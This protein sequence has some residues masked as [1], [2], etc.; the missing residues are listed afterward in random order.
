[1][2]S[3]VILHFF[4]SLSRFVSWGAAFSNFQVNIFFVLVEICR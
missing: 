2:G 4:G 1:M 3:V